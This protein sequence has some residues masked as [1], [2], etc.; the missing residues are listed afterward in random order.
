MTDDVD[1][2]VRRYREVAAAESDEISKELDQARVIMSDAVAELYSSFEQLN[3]DTRAQRERVSS[4]LQSMS[5][6]V[7]EDEEVNERLNVQ[8]FVG[9]TAAVLE[10]FAALMVHFSKQ[11]VR[12]AFKID[13]MV[14]HMDDIFGLIGDVD[15]IAEETSILAINAALEAARAGERGKG[16]SVVASEV[17][18][19]SR[20]TRE[21]NEQIA[22]R[23]EDTRLAVGDVRDAIREMASQDMNVAMDAKSGVDDMLVQLK[24]V[25]TDIGDALEGLG[26]FTERVEQSTS[27]AIRGLQ[28]EDMLTQLIAHAGGRVVRVKNALDDIEQVSSGAVDLDQAQEHLTELEGLASDTDSSPVQQGG[29]GAGDI[30]LF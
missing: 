4:L 21:L 29:M 16:F 9:Q 5:G 28:F 13:D 27:K 25:D 23:I 20:D 14:E 15:S 26:H 7:G 2:I 6:A 18:G 3:S 19:L 11:S 12:I 24:A 30:E 22:A 17:R 10:R 1:A 8:A